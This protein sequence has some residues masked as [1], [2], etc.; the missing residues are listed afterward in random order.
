M[1]AAARNILIIGEGYEPL[2]CAFYLAMRLRPLQPNIEVVLTGEAQERLVYTSPRMRNIHRELGLDE[3]KFIAA[4]G[5][6]LVYA[7]AYHS[8]NQPPRYFSTTQYGQNLQGI[9]L[10][11]ILAKLADTKSIIAWDELNLSAQIAKNKRFVLGVSN[12]P[13]P[14]FEVDF[15]Y[16]IKE[17]KLFEFLRIAS[18][19]LNI[20]IIQQPLKKIEI[21][22]D[23]VR[24]VHLKNGV[25]LRADLYLDCSEQA[26]IRQAQN[27]NYTQLISQSYVNQTTSIQQ[28]DKQYCP[29]G[30]IEINE[31]HILTRY[32]HDGL[33][34]TS[35]YTVN[36][37]NQVAYAKNAWVSNSLSLGKAYS[38]MA[39]LLYEPEAQLLR[40][41]QRLVELWPTTATEHATRQ[42]F[43]Q[44]LSLE[45]AR[46]FE[47][48]DVH[49]QL[50]HNK[51]SNSPD[52]SA[53]R[54]NLFKSSGRVIS[55]DYDPL[56]EQ[57]WPF[58]FL[59]LGVKPQSM[60]P[61]VDTLDLAKCHHVL[62]RMKMTI[63]KVIKQAPSYAQR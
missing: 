29:F 15:G 25:I 54:L 14:H 58:L 46:V 38:N 53:Q 56:T 42:A 36:P 51:S 50:L 48:T 24:E 59:A 47:V 9:N 5:A 61:L 55:K 8:K 49:F 13:K 22:N 34:H 43:N 26:Y 60:D 28:T 10:H 33:E 52:I 30:N 23:A 1:T 32:N 45:M 44:I 3:A 4:T 20:K 37:K 17:Q 11:H 21:D 16:Q 19:Q 41:L 63:D 35:I 62:T 6:G 40:P 39:T 2:L 31:R 27:I 18:L 12:L 7:Q 57:Q